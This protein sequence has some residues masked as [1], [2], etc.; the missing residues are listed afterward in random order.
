MTRT[1][2]APSGVTSVAG[3][4]AYAIKFAASPAPIDII[5]AHQIGSNKYA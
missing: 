3:A 4:Y 5:P 1:E 2:R